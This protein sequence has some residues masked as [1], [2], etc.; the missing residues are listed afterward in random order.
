[1]KKK[2]LPVILDRKEAEKL[3]D[4]PSKKSKTGIRNRA[5]LRLFLNTGLRNSEVANLKHWEIDTQTGSLRVTQG[6]GK[7]DR[8][9]WVPDTALP[10][11]KK[12]QEIRPKSAFFFCTLHETQISKRY[13][14]AMIE[15][16]AREAGIT[17][18]VYPHLLRHCFGTTHY[19]QF[20]DLQTLRKIL[21][22]EDIQTTAI[23]VTLAGSDVR[24][25]MQ[26]FVGI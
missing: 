1:M 3:L 11:L 21:G 14:G 20:K 17:K 9:L 19:R 22:H 25:S 4:Q 18:R 15:R 13:V 6:K 12:W 7:K 26:S 2:S 8:D 10:D 23:Y 5:I 16:Y 24:E